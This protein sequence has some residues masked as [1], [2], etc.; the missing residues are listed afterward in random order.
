MGEMK[1][2]PVESQFADLI[3][4][5]EPL[6]SNKLVKL[7]GNVLGWKKSTTY[8]VL[9]RLCERG[10]FQNQDGLVTSLLSKEEVRGR[11]SED[12]V[13]EAFAGSFPAMF[14]AFSSQK[15]LSDR[16]IAELEQM[17]REMKGERI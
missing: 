4:Q 9:R 5:N 13:N 12:F 17:I 8:T 11:Q 2:A 15:K 6:P 14:A 16:E 10:I 1:L 3:W 7:A